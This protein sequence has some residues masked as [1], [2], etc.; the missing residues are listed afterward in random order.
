[1]AEMAAKNAQYEAEGKDT[2]L[3]PNCM[4]GDKTIEEARGKLS[5]IQP[6]LPEDLEL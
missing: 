1:M 4:F 6:P 5:F 2:V 3:R